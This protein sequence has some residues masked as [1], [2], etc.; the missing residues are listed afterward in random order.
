MLPE[1][2]S[3]FDKLIAIEALKRPVGEFA[4]EAKVA[5]ARVGLEVVGASY[6][7][8]PRANTTAHC[9]GI[10][11]EVV[12]EKTASHYHPID[13]TRRMGTVYGSQLPDIA[14]RNGLESPYIDLTY[15]RN[16]A[17]EVNQVEDPGAPHYGET[18]VV[19]LHDLVATGRLHAD[20][21]LAKTCK[22]FGITETAMMDGHVVSP[23]PFTL[24]TADLMMQQGMCKNILE[25]GGGVSPLTELALRQGHPI[26]VVDY[27]PAVIER[28]Q[29]KYP[30]SH[31]P[32]AQFVQADASDYLRQ[33]KLDHYSLVSLGLP[34]ELHAGF[35]AENGSALAK[36]SDVL[37]VQSGMPG[38]GAMEHDI[39][40]GKE[41]IRKHPW[42]RR[43]MSVGTH[44]P[45]ISEQLCLYQFGIVASR[46]LP[47]M[48]Q[49]LSAMSGATEFTSPIPSQHIVW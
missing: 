40:V 7:L 25:L 19:P 27:S 11:L 10:A 3:H 15:A 38:L 39:L 36:A 49:L 48:A 28:L 47:Q 17:R 24:Y 21:P 8:I 29:Q 20:S 34:Y 16:M 23:D 46:D 6:T 1:P 13:F 42:Y 22:A 2:A 33:A 26:T 5:L 31:Y 18:S 43:E 37:I 44:F 12:S 30:T 14:E 45:Y 32:Q 4:K 9:A 35:M 41:Y